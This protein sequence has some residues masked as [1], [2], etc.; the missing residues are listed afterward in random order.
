[1]NNFTIKATYETI[2]EI[3]NDAIYN[4]KDN[5]WEEIRKP[6]FKELVLVSEEFKGILRKG[7]RASEEEV[8]DFVEQFQEE[9]RRYTNETIKRHFKDINVNLLR[10][11]N[12]KFN[13]D[14]NGAHRNWVAMEKQQIE[15]LWSKCKAECD[16]CFNEFKYIKLDWNLDQIESRHIT[17]GGDY[18]G[19]PQNSQEE[20]KM[21]DSTSRQ[22]TSLK[23]TRLLT[24]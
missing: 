17:P 13:Y 20:F 8:Q 24:E 4:L 11:F 21:R 7:L 16:E 10:K 22:Q 18:L 12:S 19:D 15:D 6:L 5:F 2:E 1:M 3:I 9:V 23:Y 14:E